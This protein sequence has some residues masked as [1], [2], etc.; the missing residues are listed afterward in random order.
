[1]NDRKIKLTV[2]VLSMIIIL[3]AI[4]TGFILHKEVWHLHLYHD[5]PLWSLHEAAGLILLALVTAHCMQHSFWFKNYSK[6]KI[7]RKRVTAILL[8]IGVIV[9][10]SGIILMFGSRSEII[11]HIHYVG[12]I[13]FTAIAIGHVAKRWKLLRNLIGTKH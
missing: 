7:D 12:A 8:V 1:M 5:T 2:D 9:A 4:I 10:I 6:I 11:S 13:L 3:A